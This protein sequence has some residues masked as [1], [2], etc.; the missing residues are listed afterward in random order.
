MV[1]VNTVAC[2]NSYDQGGFVVGPT[3]SYVNVTNPLL[4]RP[5]GTNPYL[6]G[7]PPR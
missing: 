1:A 4:D 6:P 5:E 2:L 7:M 3:G